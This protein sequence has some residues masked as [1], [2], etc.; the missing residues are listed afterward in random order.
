MEIKIKNWY[1]KEANAKK[2]LKKLENHCIVT[3]SPY[4]T[5][6]KDVY[7]IVEKKEKAGIIDIIQAKIGS[8]GEY[9]VHVIYQYEDGKIEVIQGVS[10]Y[11]AEIIGKGLIADNLVYSYAMGYY[12]RHEER[13]EKI[14]KRKE[15]ARISHQM[16]DIGG[17]TG[18]DIR[19]EIRRQLR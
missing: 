13:S 16:C 5:G 18:H 6:G 12:T 7:R 3:Y 19:Q 1:L 11:R 2:D 8:W 15:N 14:R 9:R 10:M 4:R 17:K